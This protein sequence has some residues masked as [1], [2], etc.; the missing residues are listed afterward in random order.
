M[1]DFL[2]D[3]VRSNVISITSILAHQHD[4][5]SWLKSRNTHIISFIFLR[6]DEKD[7]KKRLK[8]L[9]I[10][11]VVLKESFTSLLKW[12]I[13]L[14]CKSNFIFIHV[15]KVICSINQDLTNFEYELD[16]FLIYSIL[17]LIYC[18]TI[19]INISLFQLW[20]FKLIFIK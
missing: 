10:A 13:C 3:F 4:G 11:L 6:S 20:N 18:S 19:L 14:I 8:I 17:L 16:S 15:F 5:C 9:K 1:N 2:R 7:C 12:L